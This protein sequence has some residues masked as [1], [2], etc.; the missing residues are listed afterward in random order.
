MIVGSIINFK[1]DLDSY[2]QLFSLRGELVV[3]MNPD[4]YVEYYK[5]K[6]ILNLYHLEG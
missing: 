3:T 6:T 1:P 5:N 2:E 4:L